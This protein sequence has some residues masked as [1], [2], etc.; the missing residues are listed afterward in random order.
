MSLNL[1]DMKENMIK[2]Q[3]KP[4]GISD[5]RVIEAFLSV[6]RERF[7]SGDINDSPYFDGHIRMKRKRWLLSSLSIARLISLVKISPEDIILEIG[8]TS[9]YSTAIL[10]NLASLVI[11]VEQDPKLVKSIEKNLANTASDNTVIINSDHSLGYSK[12][13]PY[14]KIFIFGSVPKIKDNI[15]DQLSDN[16]SLVTVLIDENKEDTFGKAVVLK[17]NKGIINL[18]EYFEVFLPLMPGFNLEEKFQF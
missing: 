13:A 14:D 6:P 4:M 15:T 2:G 18:F 16:G 3:F 10:A 7:I 11:A 1:N 12:S 9:G 17:K 5:D 8:S